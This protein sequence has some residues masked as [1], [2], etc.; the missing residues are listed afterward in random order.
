MAVSTQIINGIPCIEEAAYAVHKMWGR[1]LF[2]P[3]LRERKFAHIVK[4]P[5]VQCM[6]FR[7]ECV[8]RSRLQNYSED[9]RQEKATRD[10]FYAPDQ[11][12]IFIE[13]F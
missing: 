2:C 1:W 8:E 13:G 9:A 10:V 12:L 3:S 4:M 6:R 5:S 11:T 7:D